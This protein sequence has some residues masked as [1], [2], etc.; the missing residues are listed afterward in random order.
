MS[1]K[2]PGIDV[3]M[4]GALAE[5]NRMAIVELLR[6]GPLTVGEIANRLELRQP[7]ASKHL[8]VLSNNG[9]V[10]VKPDANRRYYKLRPEPFQALEYWVTS[11]QKNMERRFDNLDDYVREI[12]NKK[13][14]DE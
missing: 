3:S 10:E 12:Q 14:I 2:V 8:K 4:L 11:F 13:T 9:I 1:G 7:H 5:P 6:D